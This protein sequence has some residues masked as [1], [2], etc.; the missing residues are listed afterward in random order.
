[1]PASLRQHMNELAS[2]FATNVLHAIRTASLQELLGESSGGRRRAASD[3]PSSSAAVAAPRATGRKG[4]R[5]RRR[6][7]GQIGKMVEAIVELLGK[8]PAGLRAEQIRDALDLQS[9]ELPRPLKEAL[10]SGRIVKSG[11]KRA[12]TYRARGAGGGA[13]ASAGR[14]AGRRGAAKRGR[15]VRRKAKAVKAARRRKRPSR[16]GKKK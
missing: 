2:A 16:R 7:A 12:T 1:M 8:H 4:R 3:A 15:P 6:S 13:P 9:K 10:D 11:Q 5:L 14:T